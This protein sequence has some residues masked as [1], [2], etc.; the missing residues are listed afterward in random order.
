MSWR[1][2]GMLPWGAVGLRLRLANSSVVAKSWAVAV[3]FL[4]VLLAR[5]I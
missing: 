4:A 1:N 3:A 2:E 5:L